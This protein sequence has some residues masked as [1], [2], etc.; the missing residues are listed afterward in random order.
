MDDDDED[1]E[2]EWSDEEEDFYEV[3]ADDEDKEEVPLNKRVRIPSNF[4]VRLK[5]SSDKCKDYYTELANILNSY[6]G[7][8]FRMSGRLEKIKYHGETIMLIGVLRKSLKLW[9]ALDPNAY[10]FERY[11]QKDVSDK[12]RYEMV[13]MQI[14][15]GSNRALKRAEELIDRLLVTNQ[16]EKRP[17]YKDKPL[18]ELAYTLKMNKLV[19]YKRK[20]LLCQSIHVHD[21]DV[22]TN[23][24]AECYLETRDRAPIEKENFVTISLNVID[25][26]FLDGNRVTLEKLKKKGIVPE[27]C[28]GFCIT[29]GERLS[30]PLYVI[31]DDISPAA[32]KMIVLTGGRAIKLVVPQ[33]NA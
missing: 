14:R 19:K 27:E 32:V 17:R 23:E 13:P 8:S 30:K 28:N 10:D 22:L 4:R 11:H 9:L 29:A 3:D 20:E 33:I 15:V 25:K 26:E 1:E 21:A 16:A 12:K 5:I 7:F 31:A 18:Q 6:K 2:D 24:D